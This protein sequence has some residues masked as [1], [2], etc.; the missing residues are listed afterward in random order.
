MPEVTVI[1]GLIEHHGKIL[2][3]KKIETEHPFGLGGK[4]TF[5]GKEVAPGDTLRE[6][7][8]EELLAGTGLNVSLIEC[9]GVGTQ[10]RRGTYIRTLYILCAPISNDPLP[11]PKKDFQDLKWVEKPELLLE[12]DT[13]I[14]EALPPQVL[15]YLVGEQ[16]H[17][18][19]DW[20]WL[21][22]PSN[23]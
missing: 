1:L 7:V 8:E 21:H 2:I 16:T 11:M 6:A 18:I 13:Q 3:G 10:Y 19:E 17:N 20:K 15:E 5:P 9:L 23:M 22:S 12:V 14:I 4:W